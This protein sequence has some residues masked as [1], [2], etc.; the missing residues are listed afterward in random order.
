MKRVKG[1]LSLFLVITVLLCSVPIISYAAEDISIAYNFDN[2]NP[3]FAQGTVIL[4]VDEPNRG[5]YYL[6]WADDS[7]ALDG[8]YEIAK[9]DVSSGEGSYTFLENIAIPVD[10]TTLIAIKS[11]SEPSDKTVAN[12]S[13]VY[14]LPDNKLNPHTSADKTLSFEA[15]S[16]TQLDEQSSVFYTYSLDH[17]AKALENAADRNVDFITT[18]GDCINNYEDGTSKEW[19]T[20][21]RIIADSSFTNPIYETNGN[22]SMR[23]DRAYG[24]EAYITATGLG[25]DSESLGDKPWYEVTAENGDHFLFAALETSDAVGNNDEFSTEQLEWLESTI[26]KYYDDGHH[27]FVFEHAFFHGWG[28][29]DDKV[30]HYYSGGLRTTGEYP[31]NQRFREIFD[32]YTEVFL[33][34]GH[35]HLDFEYNWNYDNE[36]GQT[37]NM[38]HIPATACTTHITDGKLD[39][40]MDENSSQCYIVDCYEDM[41]I[42]N[43]LGVVDNK[44]YPQYSYIVETGSYTYEP[45]TKPTEES[46]TESSNLIDVQIENDTT[47]LYDGGTSTVA[48]YFYN[49]ASGNYYKVDNETG[50]A[51][52]PENATNLTLYRCEGEWGNG[53]KSDSVTTYW[54]KYGP[55]TREPGQTIFYV[56]GSSKYNWK[57]EEIIFPTTEP[58]TE[59][60]ESTGPVNEPTETTIYWAIPKNYSDSGY[61]Y[62]MNL[63]C[64]DG[65]YPYSARILT[66]T[67]ELYNGMKV[68]SYTFSEK[69]TKTYDELGINRIQLQAAESTSSS[70]K[71]YFQYALADKTYTVSELKD[72]IF[73]S[74]DEEPTGT[75][76]VTSDLWFKFKSGESDPTETQ[77]DI[78]ESASTEG[79]KTVELRVL[80]NTPQGWI[81]GAS[82][83][84]YLYDVDTKFRYEVTNGKVSVPENA[85]DFVI[86]R[87]DKE[88]GS[89]NKT[90][91]VTTYWNKW[92]LTAR[93]GELDIIC[94]SGDGEF[95]WLSS[96]TYEPEKDVN[97]YL[98]GYF[99]GEDYAERDY[100]FD[101]NGYLSMTFYQDSYVHILSS[102]NTSYWTN[103]WLGQNVTEATF[104]RAE[105][106]SN[107]DN[108]YVASGKVEFTLK[109]N[110]DGTLYLSYKYEPIEYDETE[111][112]KI[113][114]VKLGDVNSDGDVT[115]D[116]VTEIQRYLAE[117]NDF[118]D[119]Q[120]YAA[121]LYGNKNID[122]RCATLI[123]KHLAGMI[124]DYPVECEPDISTLEKLIS[125]TSD[126]LYRD[127][128][129]ASFVSYSKLKKQYYKYKDIDV[130]TLDEESY[131]GIYSE[132]KSS[133]DNFNLMKAN[134]NV[135]TVYF[136]T[137]SV[138]PSVRAYISNSTTEKGINS[139]ENA[140]GISKIKILPSGAKV[141]EV[142]V[143]RSKWDKIVFTD[144]VN[145]RTVEIDIP[146]E[147]YVGF[148]LSDDTK[149]D[150]GYFVP[151]KFK[152]T[153]DRS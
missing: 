61:T 65:S 135:V 63:R 58:I 105:S 15:L 55:A 38:F 52:I 2:E 75:I 118:S 136:C 12:A 81:Y 68:Y 129:Y 71:L 153:F 57:S 150:S 96:K 77:P 73:V 146:T 24:I 149:N 109:T 5:S 106:L 50:I 117:L 45:V 91:D 145:N 108:L 80:D 49:N 29:G 138:W 114:D 116:D 148:L 56:A 92:V 16:D 4:R 8:Y 89:G 151:S 119:E 141:Y 25:V 37:A 62:R 74:P 43:G 33:Y 10:A 13:A 128:R 98:V 18:S 97:Y 107:A 122:I 126:V 59:P 46:T 76:N 66:D 6:Y 85:V 19:Q 88:W 94:L 121:D 110:D 3:G 125:T 64:T 142:T 124:S 120:L 134:N 23:S 53:N 70:A 14:K 1:F 30:N 95:G 78:T 39:Y 144:G 139:L 9:L 82:A 69:Y 51:Q 147:N 137:Y 72:K 35:S 26:E 93:S 34:T 152:Y 104:Y 31:G 132:F 101:E 67:G 102:S 130:S 99:D 143:D 100:K 103:G 54:N 131:S 48:L 127:Y 11:D 7:S 40:T 27:I 123:Q 87:C 86:Y 83:K 21:Q 79:E 17:F 113:Y 42:T 32:K 41:V 44:I 36:G 28:P 60:T 20:F 133:Y 47:Y 115:I 111:L 22:H 112:E 90:D 84:L 140:Q